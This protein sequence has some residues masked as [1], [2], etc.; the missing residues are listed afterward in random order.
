MCLVV[1]NGNVEVEGIDVVLESC[2]AAIAAGD[3]REIWQ[4]L[5]NGEISNALGGKCIGADGDA[6]SLMACDG[7]STWQ[8]QGNGQLK[9]GRSGEQCLS[10]RGS[11][12]GAEDVAARSA[13]SASNSFDTIGHGANMAVDGSSSTFWASEL[14][15][16]SPV[17]I[18]IDL[19]GARKLN[20][21]EIVWEFP[22]KAFT[23]SVSTDGVKWSEVYATDSNVLSS[24]HVALGSISAW[25]VRVVM[26]EAAQAF[27][28]HSLYGIKMLSLHASR[29]QTIV[30][31]CASA[32]KSTDARDKYFETHV[33]EFAPCSS[34]ALRSELPSLE[35]AR[36]S[37]ASVIAELTGVLPKLSSCRRAVGF[38]ITGGSTRVLSHNFQSSAAR[39]ERFNSKGSLTA[40][41]VES[42]N[43]I[44][45]DA[46]VALIKE[47]RRVILATRGALS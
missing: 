45:M 8:M 6:V 40:Q 32:A 42:Q 36:A 17:A 12:A 1:A 21:A 7:G 20:A 4:H 5:P 18:T 35:A 16:E 2:A 44:H 25:K 19:G 27:Q 22:A 47:A 31:D 11:A 37:V 29:L 43:G 30:E 15:P 10:Q 13:I 38:L 41:N 28:G 34:K 14:D 3:G 33:G 23:V 26:H 9:L 46:A 24:T 39:H